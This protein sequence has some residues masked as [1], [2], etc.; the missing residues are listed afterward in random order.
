[1]QIKNVLAGVVG[2]AVLA[3][4]SNVE[5]RS[6]F[7]RA[8]ER[9]QRNRGGN[10]GNG[11]NG[12]NNG[13][14][15][16]TTLDANLIQTGSQQDGN[17]PGADGQSASATDNANFINFCQGKTLT[18]G[19]QVQS[20]SCNGIPMGNIP[21]TN[22][23]VSSVFVNPQNGDNVDEN[24]TFNIQVQMLNFAPGTF[25]NATSTYYAAPQ[26]VDSN[27]NIIGHT[28]VTVQSTGDSLNPTQPLDPKL[29]VFFKGINDAGNGQGLLSATVTDGLPAGNYRLC[30][31]SSAANHQPVLMPVAQRGAQDD[32]IRFTVV[33]MARTVRVAT[34]TT[35]P[36][37][38]TVR[39]V[40]TVRTGGASAANALGGIAAPPVTQSGNQD[41]PFE[42][43]GNTFTT[44]DAANQRACD[45]QHNQCADA[46]NSKAVNGVSVGDCQSQIAACVAD[47]A[48]SS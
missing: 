20:G 44:K 3:E 2:L 39:T 16:G 1:M 7:G 45:I 27:G 28:H 40:R 38:T 29:F 22:N 4:A 43:Q 35:L 9:R 31:M 32:C 24:T 41:R 5:R 42:V 34:P 15:G 14:N 30:S 26:D 8:L 36:I 19:E 10:G 11:N 12:G 46:V 23:M 13:G 21:S 17:N 37:P 18:N 48:A 6:L 33:R 25:T 47:L